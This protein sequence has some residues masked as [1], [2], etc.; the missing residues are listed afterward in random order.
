M[1]K[2]FLFL[3]SLGVSIASALATDIAS[4]SDLKSL[5]AEIKAGN[6]A[7]A[8]D[9]YNLTADIDIAGEGWQPIGTAVN[10]FKGTF[11]GNGHTVRGFSW[12]YGNDGIGLFGYVGSEATIENLGISGGE[13]IATGGKKNIGSLVGVLSGKVINC[14]TMA[15]ISTEGDVV[16]GLVGKM[17]AGSSLE[18]VYSAAIIMQSG[19]KAGALVG[20][21]GGSITNAYAI[22]YAHNGNGFVGADNAGIY[23]DC[24][25]DRKLYYQESGSLKV[26]PMD[27]SDDMFGL[28]AGK[29]AWTVKPNMYPQLTKFADTD[30]SKLSVSPVTLDAIAT[31]PVEHLNDLTKN[32]V[33]PSVGTW[34]KTSV[35][36]TEW[37]TLSGI[38]ATVVLP[39]D[40]SD[41]I[42]RG[43]L[44]GYTRY[45]YTRPRRID[46][47]LAGTFTTSTPKVFCYDDAIRLTD[48]WVEDEDPSQGT[49]PYTI[50]VEVYAADGV[51]LLTTLPYD[52]EDIRSSYSFAV[53]T[54]YILRRRVSDSGCVP[55]GI[56]SEGQVEF[57][58][59]PA[60]DA[61]AIE[62]KRDTLYLKGDG[63]ALTLTAN[64]TTSASGGDGDIH[65]TW[66]VNGTK[67]TPSDTESWAYDVTTKGVYV[68]TRAANDGMCNQSPEASNGQR[69]YVVFDEFKPGKLSDTTLSFCTVEE[70]EAYQAAATSA[71]G[72]S[73]KY[74]YQWY[75]V[76]TPGDTV[77]IAG[78]TTQ[79][80]P[81][82]KLT[83][84]AGGQYTVVRKA[85]DDTRFTTWMLSDN[86]LT[87]QIVAA[88][89]A[90][91]VTP[92]TEH[93]CWPYPA[94]GR[95]YT[96]AV[97][98]QTNANAGA[99]YQWVMQKPDGSSVVID[100]N[101]A[102]L[103]YD[104][105]YESITLGEDY[106]F[107]RQVR[108]SVDCP[109]ETSDNKVIIS[110]DKVD[111]SAVVLP[112]CSSDFP[113]N[114]V[115]ET[116]DGYTLTHKFQTADEVWH[117][118]N[119]GTGG[120]CDKEIDF[121]LN[122][123]VAPEIATGNDTAHVCQNMG[124][125]TITYELTEGDADIFY[126]EYSTALARYMGRRDTIGIIE[127]PGVIVI[128]DVPH[129]GIG[130]C[131]LNL[132]V[133]NSASVGTDTDAESACF[134]HAKTV[135][136]D[137]S[138][139]GYVHSKFGK[140]LF[141]DN[142]PNNGELDGEEK[143]KFKAYQW[144][145]N[146]Q[147]VEG[148]TGQYYHENG[149]LLD[150]VYHVMLTDVDGIEYRS[151]TVEMPEDS[152]PIDVSAA[153]V[154]AYPVPV[155][156]GGTVTIETNGDGEAVVYGSVG[157]LVMRAQ[158][159]GVTELTAPGRRG[160]YYVQMTMTNGDKHVVK[161]IVK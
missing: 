74:H 39:C 61:G 102:S 134:S 68:L 19:N 56:L 54:T 107:I 143:L 91:A 52:N 84:E 156:A 153:P 133:A 12:F 26:T 161:L 159:H 58:I 50:V 158:V 93:Y 154:I 73:E 38:Q 130:H 92:K 51:T 127:Y 99:L 55:E 69:T 24:Y 5:A 138:L 41:A 20:E 86:V 94:E 87:I 80:L 117:Y 89:S 34:T 135:E 44:S 1:K 116:E 139:G 23:T 2:I 67:L 63:S 106:T 33:L 140:V 43:E 66:Y 111:H 46:D 59:N 17:E 37:L 85:E 147:P 42:L 36:G 96:L 76:N 152:D 13:L 150:G 47:L 157:E 112:V 32:F 7:L 98:S 122:V 30:A 14:W 100:S 119:Q 125:I 101:T 148:A 83:L 109:W 88:V 15:K 65:Y 146:G 104:I 155:E 77:V 136:L 79:N 141:V 128:R 103:I 3:F 60:F 28:F 31:N 160:V 6:T 62:T 16:G 149:A 132:Q 129:I 95:T 72:G 45:I 145:K 105:A 49:S 97:N 22:G 137:F 78:A 108:N 8:S 110:F 151:C 81:L 123:I 29:A 142:N 126:L 90:G 21:C 27:K 9:T 114:M 48:N 118:K 124:T 35:D 57:T 144:Y 82:N 113:Y 75:L 115:Y 18:N 10:P 121:S 53:S 70:A 64:N 25:Y 11:N 120:Q 131:Y 4:L 71:T 40:E